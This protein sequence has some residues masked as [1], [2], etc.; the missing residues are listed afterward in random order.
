MTGLLLDHQELIRAA[1]YATGH[2]G[3]V[4]AGL[5]GRLQRLIEGLDPEGDLSDEEAKLARSQLLRILVTRMQLAAD[6]RRIPAIAEEKIERPI[7]VVGYMRTGTTILHSLLAEDPQSRAPQ[8]WHS[9]QPSPPPGEVPVTAGRLQLAVREL[10]R[11]IE[12]APGFLTMHPYWDK[13]ANA[14]IEDEE[15]YTLDFQNAYPSLL[16]QVATLTVQGAAGD[17]AEAYRFHKQFLQHLQWN[18]PKRH[19]VVKGTLHQFTLSALFEAYPDAICVW[20]H[21]DP[22][23]VQASALAIISVLWSG[24]THGRTDWREFAAGFA[25]GMRTATEYMLKDPLVDDP[26]VIHLRFKDVARDPLATVRGIY[27][28]AGLQYTDAFEKRMQ[29]WLSD[30][31]NRPDR[32]GRYPYSLEPFGLNADDITAQFRSYRERFGLD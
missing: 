16:Y 32:Y 12:C 24:I 5:A 21:R 1:E 20:P 18:Q 6:R 10:D 8:W 26:R 31:T 13:G 14:L 28:K 4:D 15:I 7:I 22:A 9:H 23:E 11:F 30:P 19:W 29:A 3:L 2:R 25:E 17:P 27:A